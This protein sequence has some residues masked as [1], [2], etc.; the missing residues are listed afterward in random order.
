M[1]SFWIV[2]GNWYPHILQ[3]RD[4]FCNTSLFI[5]KSGI[6]KVS[7][8]VLFVFVYLRTVIEGFVTEHVFSKWYL[9]EFDQ[10]QSS[11]DLCFQD[12]SRFSTEVLNS[13]SAKLS[14]PASVFSISSPPTISPLSINLSL[15]QPSLPDLHH[16]LCNLPRQNPLLN[17]CGEDVQVV[18]VS[19]GRDLHLYIANNQVSSILL[20][21]PI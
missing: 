11:L 13:L 14:V 17:I 8:L 1:H 21:T 19:H 10:G 6:G 18:K 3:K 20:Y 4:L 16:K 7:I 12:S 9:M 5:P 2:L 15:T